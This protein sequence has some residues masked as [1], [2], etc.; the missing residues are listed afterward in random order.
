M[1][2]SRISGTGAISRIWQLNIS[3]DT[4][5]FKIQFFSSYTLMPAFIQVVSMISG[6]NYLRTSATLFEAS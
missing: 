2:A 3:V 4:A 1:E 6:T 5:A